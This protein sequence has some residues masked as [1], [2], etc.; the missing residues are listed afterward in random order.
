MTTNSGSANTAVGS[1]GLRYN[2]T[3]SYNTAFGG[4]AGTT[5]TTGS[6]NT[7]LGREADANAATY[8]NSSAVG[9]GSTIT[10]SNQVVLGTV[11][12]SVII[13]N[14]IQFSYSSVPTLGTTSLGY[15]LDSTLS[16][17]TTLTTTAQVI[18]TLSIP[19]AGVWFIQA[20][21]LSYNASSAVFNNEYSL[22][23]VVSGSTVRTAKFI[24]NTSIY[25][26]SPSLTYIYSAS[27][28]TTVTTQALLTFGT[29]RRPTRT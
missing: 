19:N 13:P 27:S 17:V 10:G 16:A 24:I 21:L 20:G 18:R 14:Q 9:S 25:T 26:A 22:R 2:T 28:A 3:G 4:G 5:N 29:I 12:E 8:S 15:Y 1:Y 6:Y 11:N 7:Y 23:L